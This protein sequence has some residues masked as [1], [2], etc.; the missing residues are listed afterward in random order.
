[1]PL[2]Q[3]IV[4]EFVDAL[5]TANINAYNER[6]DDAHELPYSLLDFSRRVM[7]YPTNLHFYKSLLG[8][9]YNLDAQNTNG[10]AETLD[11][12]IDSVAYD[13]ISKMLAWE[14]VNTW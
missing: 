5:C 14:G 1:M 10:C 12:L 8:L 11:K 9:R 13:I 4:Q 3:E 7:P 6:Y 2:C